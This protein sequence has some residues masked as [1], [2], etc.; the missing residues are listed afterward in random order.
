MKSYKNVI[1]LGSL[2]SFSLIPRIDANGCAYVENLWA[3]PITPNAGKVELLGGKGVSGWG[4]VWNWK[5]A[6]SGS[7][8][9]K[10]GRRREATTYCLIDCADN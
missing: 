7:M 2:L 6:K 3:N 1:R 10:G 9:M 5:N 4:K 8:F